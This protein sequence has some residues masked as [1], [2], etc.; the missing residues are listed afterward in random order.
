MAKFIF[1][2]QNI[3][4]IKLRLEDQA[5]TAY[6]EAR[7]KLNE[8]ERVLQEFEDRKTYYEQLTRS[9]IYQE[10]EVVT[11]HLITT[12]KKEIENTGVVSRKL[13]LKEIKA[14]ENAIET[15]KY[16]IKVQKIKV[17]Q[18]EHELETAR[19]K[20]NIAMM[21]RKTYEKLKENA[22]EE[23]KKEIDAAERK[24]IDELV[25]FKFNNTT[26]SEEDK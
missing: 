20:L 22:F 2:M 4:D 12:N 8:E 9:L 7:A 10:S 1:K 6:G 5:K 23:F 21:E 16:H 14:Y 26:S 13:N 15:I 3:L 11:N 17:K 19:E 25:S 18:A 24:E